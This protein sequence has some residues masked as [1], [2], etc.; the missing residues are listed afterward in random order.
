VG[1]LTDNVKVFGF[2]IKNLSSVLARNYKKA[3]PAPT[4]K[5]RMSEML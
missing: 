3:R 4:A 2:V 5:V 1:F